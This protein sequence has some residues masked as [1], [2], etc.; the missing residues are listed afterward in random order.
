VGL[1]GNEKEA[2]F[3]ILP[4]LRMEIVLLLCILFFVIE[5]P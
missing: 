5:E 4:P 3:K 1:V 2:E